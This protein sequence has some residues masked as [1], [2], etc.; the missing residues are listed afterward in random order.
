MPKLVK[1]QTEKIY[2]PSTIN[3]PNE[4]DRA[5]VEL[6]KQA[7]G[8]DVI[9]ASFGTDNMDRTAR[10]AASLIVAW[11]FTDDEGNVEPI[12]AEKVSLMMPE[13]FSAVVIKV[14]EFVNKSAE[15]KLPQE[16][17]KK[18]TSTDILTPSIQSTPT[19]TIPS[20]R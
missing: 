13:D 18:T 4:D 20:P 7:V 10:L 19:E 2:L 3:E 11:N 8:G 17:E 6:K 5:W 15:S 12:T 1:I 9:N 16:G 14:K